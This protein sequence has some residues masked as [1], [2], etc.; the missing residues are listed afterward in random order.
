MPYFRQANPYIWGAEGPT[1]LKYQYTYIEGKSIPE[2]VIFLLTH[3]LIVLKNVFF[4]PSF[5]LFSFA[6]L[7][8]LFLFIPI[9]RIRYLVVTILTL[10]IYSLSDTPGIS[11]YQHQYLLEI[12][13]PLFISFAHALKDIKDN[14]LKFISTDKLLKLLVVLFFTSFVFNFSTYNYKSFRAYLKHKDTIE[15]IKFVI[16]TDQFGLNDKDAAI[17]VHNRI[18]LLLNWHKY[19]TALMNLNRDYD[20]YARDPEIKKWYYI[21]FDTA[22]YGNTEMESHIR[23]KDKI[24]KLGFKK[25]YEYNEF[26]IYKKD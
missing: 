7:F 16:K 13:M 12:F 17:I 14:E 15:N 9:I 1:Y 8:A 2:I 25:I 11:K 20:T 19:M 5:K 18:G 21:A 4:V 22:D 24:D 26:I 23:D 6:G 3:P 10:G